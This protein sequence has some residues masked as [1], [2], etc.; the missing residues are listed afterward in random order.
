MPPGPEDLRSRETAGQ[1]ALAA[2]A[3]AIKRDDHRS[4]VRRTRCV[5]EELRKAGQGFDSPRTGSWFT[6]TE[7]HHC[8]GVIVAERISKDRLDALLPLPALMRSVW[9]NRTAC[10]DPAD[11]PGDP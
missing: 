11:D 7:G 8:H 9:R 4:P 3:S 6:L 10:G 1:G 5:D 2:R